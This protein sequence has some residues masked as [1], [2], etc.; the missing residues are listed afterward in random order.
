MRT[1]SRRALLAE[2]GCSL[3]AP[4]LLSRA[5]AQ[6]TPDLVGLGAVEPLVRMLENTPRERCAEAVVDR[7]RAGVTYREIMAAAFLA[8][9]RN[10]NPRPPGFALHC[11]FV[12]HS[13][14]QLSL[15]AP[16]DARLLPLFYAIDNFKEAQDRDAKSK[17]GDYT[18]KPLSGA[19]TAPDRAAT[20]LAAAFDAWDAERAERAAAALARNGS[21]PEAFSLL[22]AYGA[23]DYRNIGHKAIF[24]ANAKRTLDVIGWRYAEP[25]LRSLALGLADFGPTLQM[26]GF[27]YDDQSYHGNVKRVRDGFSKLPSAWASAPVDPVAVKDAVSAIA[28][29]APD[30][31]CS[32]VASLIAKG[33][34][35]SQAAWDAVTLSA[36]ELRMRSRGGAAFVGV[37]AVTAANGLRYSWQSA[38]DART[39]YLLTLQ[40]AG[41]MAQFH[42]WAGRNPADLLPFSIFDLKP[43][44][45]TADSVLADSKSKPEQASASTLGLASGPATRAQYLA[46][47]TRNAIAKADE[48]HFFKYLVALLEDSTAVSDRWQPQVLAA[49]PFY[50]KSASDPI[51]PAMKRAQEA[52]TKLSG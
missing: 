18:M 26:N 24:T 29:L 50:A 28:S 34:L 7:M 3:A 9:V 25:V 43:R 19:L 20:E 16:A 12:I 17:T 8:G 6:V 23:R 2:A 49:T 48:A 30:E 13:A 44:E 15:E 33:R 10:V 14:H 51:A 32:A 1:L 52:L 5:Q 22:W 40:G 46:A 36:C 4:V 11:V 37:H 45:G 38:P 41:W 21:A 31:A 35:S 27:A 42:R 47:A 39:R